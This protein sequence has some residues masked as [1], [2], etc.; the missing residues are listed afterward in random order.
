MELQVTVER[1]KEEKTVLWALDLL[2]IILQ[3]FSW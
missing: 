1:M 2:N 3:K